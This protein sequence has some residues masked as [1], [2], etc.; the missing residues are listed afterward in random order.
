MKRDFTNESKVN[1]LIRA[2]KSIFKRL[3]G[4]V[5]YLTGFFH[6]DSSSSITFGVGA[7]FINSKSIKFGENV[8]FGLFSR[9]E[10]YQGG[11]ITFGN[12]SSCG[13]YV[14]IGSISEVI[15][16]NNV[17]IGSN[18]L[19]ID[20]NHGK[21]KVDLKNKSNI[22]PRDRE[23]SS[24]GKIIVKDNVWIGDGVVILGGVTIGKGSIIGANSIVKHNIDENTIYTGGV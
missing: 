21:P 19:I 16:E 24:K 1:L 15:I 23:V 12:N 6:S 5:Y 10:C 8:H 20:H 17:L 22:P 13:D 11:K 14:H 3:R 4:K 7:R 2:I 18:V 9:L